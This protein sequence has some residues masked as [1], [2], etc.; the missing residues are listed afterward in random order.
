MLKGRFQSLRELRLNIRK[1]KDVQIAVHWIQC[2]IILHNM[3]IRFENHHRKQ[4][5]EYEGSLEWAHVEG[6]AF[7]SHE[8]EDPDGDESVG[9]RSYEGTLGQATHLR[10]MGKLFDSPHSRAQYRQG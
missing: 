6:E 8:S 2:C 9:D 7:M 10:L 1:E 3:I 5:G 4:D